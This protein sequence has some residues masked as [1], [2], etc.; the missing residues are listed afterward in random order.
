MSELN[1]SALNEAA[2]N[3]SPYIAGVAV[4][5]GLLV[6]EGFNCDDRTYMLI[7]DMPDMENA[8]EKELDVISVPRAPGIKVA[9]S[10]TRGKVITARGIVK[11]STGPLM[12]AYL[13]TIKQSLRTQ[14]GTLSVTYQGITRRYV[15]TLQNTGSMFDGRAS[16]DINKC[17]FELQFLTE[18]IATDW[19]YT[20]FTQQIT[21]LLDTIAVSSV[22]STETDCTIVVVVAAATGIT[23]LQIGSDS[24]GGQIKYTGAIA[25]GDVFVFDGINQQ[26]LKNGVEV[27]FTGFFPQIAIGSDVLRFTST[28]TSIDFRATISHRNAYL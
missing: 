4:P 10:N 15:A 17:P 1:L 19:D 11:A 6:F 26:V 18:G 24:T 3:D 5:T 14:G 16:T 23:S 2:L 13:D 12:R 20:Y 28:G 8:P 21:S 9:N 7:T 27:N 22:G 25:A